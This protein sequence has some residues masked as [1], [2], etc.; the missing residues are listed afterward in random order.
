MLTR[1]CSLAVE[2]RCSSVLHKK[3]HV[4]IV[5]AGSSR[6]LGAFLVSGVV[7]DRM[8]VSQS[9]ETFYDPVED[10][11]NTPEVVALTEEEKK[12]H[13][14]EWKQE[15]LKVS[16]TKSAVDLKIVGLI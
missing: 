11:H 13:E 16:A 10:G 15:L 2:R 12:R 8:M 1:S 4:I 6:P 14:E 5:S 9:I 3:A 7:C